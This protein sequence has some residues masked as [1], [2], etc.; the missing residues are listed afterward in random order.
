M[1]HPFIIRIFWT[2]FLGGSA[3]YIDYGNR[4]NPNSFTLIVIYIGFFYLGMAKKSVGSVRSKALK[5]AF[6]L[7]G[8]MFGI[9]LDILYRQYYEMNGIAILWIIPILIRMLGLMGVPLLYFGFRQ[10]KTE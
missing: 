8:I 2:T 7:A 4:V 5:V 1:F 6:G 9:M 3:K 10:D